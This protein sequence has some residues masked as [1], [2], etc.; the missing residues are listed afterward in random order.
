M[1][2]G[3]GNVHK[4]ARD[5]QLKRRGQVY[6]SASFEVSFNCDGILKNPEPVKVYEPHSSHGCEF[7][8]EAPTGTPRANSSRG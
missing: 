5:P 7:G 8:V 1:V 3:C 6:A 4:C 2:R